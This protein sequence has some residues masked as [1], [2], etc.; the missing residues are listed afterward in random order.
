[1]GNDVERIE[2]LAAKMHQIWCEYTEAVF[3]TCV[4]HKGLG[5]YFIPIH[6]ERSWK[7]L[8]KKSFHDLGKKNKERDR[9]LAAELLKLID[10]F[11]MEEMGHGT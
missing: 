2:L 5:L 7:A 4:K 6:V 3:E 1:M 9:K 10:S 11:D 8:C